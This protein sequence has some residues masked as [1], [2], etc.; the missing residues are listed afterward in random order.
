MLVK[1]AAAPPGGAGR[2]ASY[3]PAEALDCIYPPCTVPAKSM[4]QMLVRMAAAAAPRG[5][6]GAAS[7]GACGAAGAGNLCGGCHQVA[8]C[9]VACQRAAWPAHKAACKAAA[10]EKRTVEEKRKP[11][12]VD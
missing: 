10:V 1:A 5:G 2:T 7:C 6:A 3:L 9:A 4:I 11:V 12:E 8:Y